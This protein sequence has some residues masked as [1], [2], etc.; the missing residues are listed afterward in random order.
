MKF[1]RLILTAS[2]LA[3]TLA[4]AAEREIVVLPLNYSLPEQVLPPVLAIL[5]EDATVTSHGNQLIL[6]V[7]PEEKTDVEQ[8]LQ[9]IDK[10][11]RQFL[12]S[13]RTPHSSNNH[14]S[15]VTASGTFANDKVQVGSSVQNGNVVIRNSDALSTEKQQQSV[16]ATEGM[17]AYVAVGESVPV[18][19]YRINASGQRE[20]VTEFKPANK[21]FYVT[22]R[23]VGSNVVLDINQTNDQHQQN[24]IATKHLATQISGPVGQWITI[25]DTDSKSTT[26]QSGLVVRSSDASRKSG[27]IQLRVELLN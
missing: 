16:R 14:Q 2:C 12:I 15:G 18:H 5:P 13:V 7:T 10:P 17:P 23:L 21:G 25:G 26:S 11:A 20:V 3:M 8:L 27:Q 9:Q 19:S 24:R 4:H 1:W 6:K 22:A